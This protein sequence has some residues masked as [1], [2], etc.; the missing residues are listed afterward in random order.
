MYNVDI[1]DT[2]LYSLILQTIMDKLLNVVWKCYIRYILI[3]VTFECLLVQNRLRV[4]LCKINGIV[5]F[6]G[7]K[8]V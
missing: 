2:R 8:S 6:N 5:V 1:K 3:S 4:R 7:H